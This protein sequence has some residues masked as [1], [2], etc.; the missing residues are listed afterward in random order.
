MRNRNEKALTD[1]EGYQRRLLYCFTQY[2]MS[3]KHPSMTI[4]SSKLQLQ[5]D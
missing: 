3:D 4:E 2:S 5:Y 1:T